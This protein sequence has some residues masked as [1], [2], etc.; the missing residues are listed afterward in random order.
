MTP[1]IAGQPAPR[2]ENAVSKPTAFYIKRSLPIRREVETVG[3]Y[4]RRYTRNFL[5][6]Y[7]TFRPFATL[8]SKI[9]ISD[10]SYQKAA[11]NMV[12]NIRNFYFPLADFTKKWYNNRN[13]IL[14]KFCCTDIAA[15]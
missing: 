11:K 2:K 4:C 8:F 1:R 6:V 15:F 14:T 12:H 9:H 5:L 7:H 10:N 13:F 3:P